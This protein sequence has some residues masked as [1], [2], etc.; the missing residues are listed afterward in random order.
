M[1]GKQSILKDG[2]KLVRLNV[3]KPAE[4]VE[5]LYYLPDDVGEE[6]NLIASDQAKADILRLLMKKAHTESELFKW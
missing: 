3:S 5:E 6:H 4:L 2:W 1:G